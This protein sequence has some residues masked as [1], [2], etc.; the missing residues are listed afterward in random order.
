MVDLSA[1]KKKFFVPLAF[2]CITILMLATRYAGFYSF[3]GSDDLHYAFLSNHVL[4]GSYDMFFAQDIYAGR[5]LVVMYQA[6]WFK[7]FGINDLTMCMPS[8]SVLII[9]AYLVCFKSGLQKNAGTIIL[10]SSLIYFNPVVS[11]ATLGNLPDVYI[12]LIALLVFLLIKKSFGS[13]L[14]KQH[15]LYGFIA[16]LLLLAGL[17]VKENIVLIYAGVAVALFYYGKRTSRHFVIA[18]ATTVFIGAAGYL[19]FYYINT[20][21]WFYRFVQIK[22]A[23]YFNECSYQCLPQTE[24]VK[25]LTITVPLVAALAGAYPLLLLI[26]AL[27]GKRQNRAGDT[28]FWKITFISLLLLA[29]YF[30][31]SI[32]P[33]VPLCHDIRQF[34]FLFPFAAIL[35]TASLRENMLEENYVRKINI[36]GSIVF[37][38]VT[39]ACYFFAPYNKW[40]ILCNSLLCIIFILNIFS[41]RKLQQLFFYFMIPFILWLSTAYSIYKKPH[42]GYAA[43]KTTDQKLKQQT[44]FNSNTYYFLNNDTKTH[45]ALINQFN[46]AKRFLN[47]DTV[48]KGFKPF[49]AYQQQQIFNQTKGIQHGWLIVSDAYPEN[50]GSATISAVKQLLAGKF[51]SITINETTAWYLTSAETAEKIMQL[52]NRNTV[53]GDCY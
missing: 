21:D 15:I 31:F 44:N 51:F 32:S 50:T 14:A 39:L 38:L 6:L 5:T 16:A 33:Y 8:L 34:F 47:F 28:R 27:F 25:R 29:L 12:A 4:N 26:T 7:L 1:D 52:V 42:D 9:L 10:A 49:A 23:A 41:N 11:R 35:F 37:A 22:N 18:L 45:V 53:A 13:L 19:L 43:L 48:Q 24:L 20:G 30:P 36:S 40:A 3:K 17:F 46:T 2:C